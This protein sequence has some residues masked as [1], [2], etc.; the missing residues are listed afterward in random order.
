MI[1]VCVITRNE[2]S[3]LEKCLAALK[4]TA[5]ELVVVD[6][7]STDESLEIANRYA[8]ITGCFT[9]CDDFAA[10]RN[11]AAKIATNDIIL[12]IDS[13]EVLVSADVVTL[14]K[15][16]STSSDA[17]G[18]IIRENVYTRGDTE[19][20]EHE[21]ICRI[22]DRRSF[23]YKG[24][25]HEQIVR[26]DGGPIHT[27]RAPISINHIGYDG[28]DQFRKDK[29]ERN[30]RLLD[31]TLQE[32]GP[33]PYIFYQLGKS[34]YMQGDYTK[35]AEYFEQTFTYDLDPKLEYL[36]DAVESY[37][38]ALINCGQASRALP[39]ANL[40]EEFS[41]S[42]DYVFMMAFVYMQNKQFD[43]SL[44]EFVK[45]TSYTSCKV[46]GVN[47]Y[48]AYYNAGVICECTGH[49]KDAIEFYKKAGNY[50][51]ALNRLNQCSE[52]Y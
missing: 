29:T 4:G 45:A 6:T 3:N 25:I 18:R 14:T 28:S 52:I 24:R 32:S 16:I 50:P 9:W 1:S 42:A 17:I 10:A 8:D 22:Y 15:L 13:D 19:F 26:L 41:W 7:G 46:Q 47:S 5:M 38:Y 49:I 35:A 11:Y 39:L 30:I 31:M 43:K 23:K 27:Y 20:H 12:M 37:G 36:S 51:K 40:Y 21:L 34:Y 33:D 2:A 48:L 44:Q